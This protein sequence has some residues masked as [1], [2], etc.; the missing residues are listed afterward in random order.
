M[1]EVPDLCIAFRQHL[2]VFCGRVGRGGPY[3]D[4]RLDAWALHRDVSGDHRYGGL[5]G[6][7]TDV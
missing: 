6:T 5:G 4:G 2:R 3:A 1:V 7:T